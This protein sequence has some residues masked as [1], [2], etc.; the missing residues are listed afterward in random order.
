LSNEDE[1][2]DQIIERYREENG[3]I[4]GLLQDVVDTA[5]KV[6]HPGNLL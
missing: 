3:S 6:V 4:I 5:R 1:K 2:L